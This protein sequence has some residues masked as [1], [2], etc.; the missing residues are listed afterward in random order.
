MTHFML[1][2]PVSFTDINKFY[3]NSDNFDMPIYFNKNRMASIIFLIPKNFLGCY[4]LTVI[5]N[6]NI[7]I[8]GKNHKAKQLLSVIISTMTRQPTFIT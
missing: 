6:S 1:V 8:L 4:I 3:S 2:F 7:R 5:K